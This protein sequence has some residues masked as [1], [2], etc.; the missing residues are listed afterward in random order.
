VEGSDDYYYYTL[1]SLLQRNTGGKL[2]KQINSILKKYA[3]SKRADPRRVSGITAKAK[4]ASP[5]FS[6]LLLSRPLSSCPCH[7][8][9]SFRTFPLTR[10]QQRLQSFDNG[11]TKAKE[12]VFEWLVDELKLR[13]SASSEH[14]HVG[15]AEVKGNYPSQLDSAVISAFNKKRP[16]KDF[17]SFAHAHLIKNR[18]AFQGKVNLQSLS[19]PYRSHYKAKRTPQK[20][21]RCRP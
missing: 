12:E 4:L 3:S 11:T 6:S 16:L 19:Q 14:S 2:T 17:R 8:F 10:K 7:S 20:F 15:A 13:F 9:R 1:L 5:P 21:G 18:K